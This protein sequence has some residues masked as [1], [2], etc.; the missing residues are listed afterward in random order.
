M[1]A[2]DAPDRR[3]L[4]V[5]LRDAIA[6]IASAKLGAERSCLGL[7]QSRNSSE[8]RFYFRAYMQFQ[9]DWRSAKVLH[10]EILSELALIDH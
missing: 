5:A 3:A 9:V 2:T 4:H 1:I 10:E 6:M 7:R 8:R